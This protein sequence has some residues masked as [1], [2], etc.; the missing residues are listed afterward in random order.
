M[1]VIHSPILFAVFPVFIVMLTILPGIEFYKHHELWVYLLSETHTHSM[2]ELIRHLLCFP[3]SCRP[4]NIPFYVGTVAPIVVIYISNWILYIIILGSLIKR[5]RE[6]VD[7]EKR[8]KIRQQLI[9]AMSLAV[10]FGLGWGIGFAASAEIPT[11]LRL[12]ISIIFTFF[13]AFQGLFIFLFQCVYSKAVR[14]VWKQ[15][16]K[17]ILPK[18]KSLTTSA[19]SSEDRYSTLPTSV[20]QPMSPSSIPGFEMK[21][22]SANGENTRVMALLMIYCCCCSV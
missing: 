21:P 6:T 9:A 11:A 3:L 12:P 15:Y 1:T 17:K 8:K 10:L 4:F 13:A 20:K 19:L 14:D 22:H 7:K 5:N 2:C 18:Q 16:I